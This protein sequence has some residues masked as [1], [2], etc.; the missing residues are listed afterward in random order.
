MAAA[1]RPNENATAVREAEWR[2]LATAHKVRSLGFS[3]VGDFFLLGTE[4]GGVEVWDG[5]A[6]PLRARSFTLP[7]A[8]GSAVVAVAWSW[9]NQLVFAAA[10]NGVLAVF[11]LQGTQPMAACR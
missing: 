9:N 2:T 5:T 10:G 7:A 1:L 11:D 4:Q 3:A 6:M 8:E